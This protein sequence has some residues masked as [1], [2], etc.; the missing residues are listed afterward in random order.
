MENCLFYD[1]L[2][3]GWLR[4]GLNPADINCFL[5]HT[6]ILVSHEVYYT[7][8]ISLYLLLLCQASVL[9]VEM[10][11]KHISWKLTELYKNQFKSK[12]TLMYCDILRNLYNIVFLFICWVKNFGD[13]FL[14]FNW[15][16]H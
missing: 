16:V 12:F 6:G 14:N 8:L 15:L 5:S 4:T 13:F 10:C 2:H 7:L 11:K 1:V 3:D 9:V